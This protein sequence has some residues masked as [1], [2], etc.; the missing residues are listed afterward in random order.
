MYCFKKPIRFPPKKKFAFFSPTRAL[1]FNQKY[2]IFLRKRFSFQELISVQKAMDD[3]LREKEEEFMK[4]KE[5]KELITS[6]LNEL[7]LEDKKKDDIK[8]LSVES[9]ELRDELTRSKDLVTLLNESLADNNSVITELKS[10]CDKL[11]NDVNTA[12][13][14]RIQISNLLSSTET[15]LEE[16]RINS[17]KLKRQMTQLEQD[18]ENERTEKV[19]IES[20]LEN[21]LSEKNRI[22]SELEEEKLTNGKICLKLTETEQTNTRLEKELNRLSGKL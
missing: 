17:D 18:L 5:E 4:L 9:A 21:A 3:S 22:R 19:E 12:E 8:D 2:K 10:T 14:T 20:S 16:E 6:E 7:K 13:N 11:K 15:K 1:N